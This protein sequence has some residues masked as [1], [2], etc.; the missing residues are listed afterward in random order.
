M[1]D[2]FKQR[3]AKVRERLVPAHEEARLVQQ[4]GEAIR[5]VL[6]KLLDEKAAKLADSYDRTW[7]KLGATTAAEARD[8]T[9][10]QLLS[11]AEA[12]KMLGCS[13]ATIKRMVYEGRLPQPV[14]ISECRIGHR[15]SDLKKLVGAERD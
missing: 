3:I 12:A 13:I 14:Q 7:S 9:A 6:D 5:P 2:W 11:Q 15:Y 4:Y 8:L 1:V 10:P